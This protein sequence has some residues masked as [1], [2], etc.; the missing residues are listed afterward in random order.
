M[1]VGAGSEAADG[2]VRDARAA[3]HRAAPAPELLEAIA[4]EVGTP[5]YVYDA[6]ALDAGVGRWTRAA[7]ADRIWYAVKANANLAVLRRLSGHG[8]G[9]EAATPGELACVRAAGV[10]PARTMLGGVPKRP[11]EVG[12]ALC[13]GLDLVV[14]QAGEE[15]DEAVAS[16]DRVRPA[17]VGLRVRPGIRAGAHPSL[18]TGVPDAKFGLDPEEGLRAWR[19]LSETP[20]LEPRTLSVHLGSGVDSPGPYLR[21]VDLLL[22]LAVEAD[23]VGAPV[24]E[25]DL[26]GGL[27]VDY[28]GASDPEPADL[29]AAVTERLGSRARG[30]G[31][32]RE[33]TA[34]DGSGEAGVPGLR[35]EPG[36][37]IVARMGLL[38]ARVLYR[39]ERRGRRAVVCDAA[40]T[41]FAR[42]VLYG[43]AHR[44]EPVRGSPS[45]P[46]ATDLLGATCES[47]DVL[48]RD[49]RLDG[50]APGDLL[51]VRDTGAYGFAMASNYNGRPRPAEVLVED[52][53]WRVVRQREELADLWRGAA[54]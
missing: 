22:E 47:G 7:P 36:R 24:L 35:W 20:G 34:G 28:A 49:L 51:V 26:G 48:G 52:G 19:R 4:D 38:L 25:L 53:S 46:A 18:E 12:R 50:L 6:R 41:D 23:R 40:F 30:S 15:V 9:F 13:A 29:V 42:H 2:R 11:S 5:A 21:A 31:G 37:S 14:L 3:S 27:A 43:A 45:G 54:P 39:R 17:R 16:A 10:E 8:L 33:G 1:P 32:A 44:V